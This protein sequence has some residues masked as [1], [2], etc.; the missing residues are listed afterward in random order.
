MTF[1]RALFLQYGTSAV[2]LQGDPCTVIIFWS[3]VHAH[4]LYSARSPITYNEVIKYGK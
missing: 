4:L 2:G 1:V 3:I